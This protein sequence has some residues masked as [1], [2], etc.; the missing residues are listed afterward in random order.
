MQAVAHAKR[1][2]LVSCHGHAVNRAH[3]RAE[4]RRA[5]GPFCIN[6]PNQTDSSH[7]IER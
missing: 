1:Q 7:C 4:L 6:A 5:A 2:R 3:K